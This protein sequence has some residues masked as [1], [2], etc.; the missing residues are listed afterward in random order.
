MILLVRDPEVGAIVGVEVEEEEVTIVEIEI[1]AEAI[2]DQDLFLDV[3]TV[4]QIE[5]LHQVETLKEVIF[6]TI[7]INPGILQEIAPTNH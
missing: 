4:A 1:E 7:V 5:I 3:P 6:V 2:V